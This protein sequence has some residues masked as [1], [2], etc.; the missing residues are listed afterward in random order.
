MKKTESRLGPGYPIEVFNESPLSVR[1]H[2]SFFLNDKMEGRMSKLCESG[3]NTKIEIPATATNVSYSI[4]G[5]EN[6][7]SFRI[8]LSK[9]MGKPYRLAMQIEKDDSGNVLVKDVRKK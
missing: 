5:K 6:E 8:V 3:V 9:K 4:L 7:E 2:A 1:L